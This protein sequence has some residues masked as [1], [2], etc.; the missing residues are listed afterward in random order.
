MKTLINIWQHGNGAIVD[1]SGQALLLRP[2]G[3]ALRVV[4]AAGSTNWLHYPLPLHQNTIQPA[5]RLLRIRVRYRCDSPTALITN[6]A[7]FDAEKSVFK[8]SGLGLCAFDWEEIELKIKD[9]LCLKHGLNLSI[10]VRFDG[11]DDETHALEISSV[12]IEVEDGNA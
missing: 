9:N 10:G 4:G 7:L 12:G 11:S 1:Y 6:I 3:N 5:I 8:V 2:I